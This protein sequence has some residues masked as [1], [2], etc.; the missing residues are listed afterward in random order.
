[1]LA[2]QKMRIITIMIVAACFIA[3]CNR[4]HPIKTEQTIV[5]RQSPGV[6]REIALRQSRDLVQKLW[7]R[8]D[9]IPDPVNVTENSNQWT[10]VYASL[11][12]RISGG[13]TLPSNRAYGKLHET[14]VIVDKYEARIQVVGP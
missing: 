2:E 6:S 12:W 13:K 5:N 4:A 8:E 3:G 14:K 7:P 10:L 9:G 11:P 1:M